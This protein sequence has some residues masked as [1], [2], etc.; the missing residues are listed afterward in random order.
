VRVKEHL[1]CAVR[2]DPQQTAV[3]GGTGD[4]A[5]VF[6]HLQFQDVLFRTV[7]KKHGLSAGELVDF[8]RCSA[9]GIQRSGAQPVRQKEVQHK[10]ERGCDSENGTHGQ[11]DKLQLLEY[12]FLNQ[13]K[14]ILL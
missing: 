12:V 8:S 10:Q 7:K 11:D 6:K 3:T 5:A 1:A 13:Q 14:R 4:D 9:C 2:R